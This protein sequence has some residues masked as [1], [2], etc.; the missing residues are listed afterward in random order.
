MEREQIEE[1][2][3]GKPN[4]QRRFTQD[5]PILP[6][7]WIAYGTNPKARYELLLTPH[8]KADAPLAAQALRERLKTERNALAGRP[9]SWKKQHIENEK[10]RILFNESVILP[11]S[12][13]GN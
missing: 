7:V 9:M 12:R 1:L 4:Q 11:T 13:S 5:F 3:Y 6:D 8:S 10:P 2:F